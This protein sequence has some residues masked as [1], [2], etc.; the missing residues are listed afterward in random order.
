MHPPFGFALFYL[1]GIADTLFKEGRLSKPILSNDIYLGAIPWVIMQLLLVVVVIFVPQS[2]T[3]FLDKEQKVDIDSV[4]IE[5]PADE[6]NPDNNADKS[7]DVP[8]G[9]V[10]EEHQNKVPR[11]DNERR[12]VPSAWTHR[13]SAG[14]QSP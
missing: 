1:R 10:V 11:A 5:L 7:V 14:G 2:V 12:R 6:S 8:V 4:V 9:P 13:P 3:F